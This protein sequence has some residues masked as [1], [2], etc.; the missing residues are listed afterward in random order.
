MPRA[1]LSAVVFQFESAGARLSEP[2]P[3][4]SGSPLMLSGRQEPLPDG[5]GS[6]M[7]AETLRFGDDPLRMSR[8]AGQ[9]AVPSAYT[10][11]ELRERFLKPVDSD[12]LSFD[13]TATVAGR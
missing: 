4:G 11:F 5:R 10:S 8:R 6:E 2:R 7:Q 1:A 12:K 3:S 9:Q 13:G